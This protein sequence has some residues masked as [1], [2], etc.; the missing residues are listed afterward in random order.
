[1]QKVNTIPLLQPKNLTFH[2]LCKDI[3][4][5][6][7]AKALLGLNLKFCPSN[8]TINQDMSKTLLKMAYS[9]CTK[10]QLDAM[11]L[12]D[13]SNFE[14]QIYTKNKNWNP[15]PAPLIIEEKLTEF[16]KALNEEKNKIILKYTGRNLNNLMPSQRL[17]LHLLKHN[18]HLTI[19]PT[20]KNLGPAV[21]ETAVYTKQVL[22]EHL[23]T[24]DYK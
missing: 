10:F 5:P 7:G 8:N 24:K 1:M 2:N 9:I 14:K 4:L 12:S 22:T 16:G 3:K 23:L 20:D 11:G 21:V 13:N 18:K 15:V 19:K 6:I 17:V